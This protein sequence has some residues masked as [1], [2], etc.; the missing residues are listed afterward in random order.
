MFP[1]IISG[2]GA[3]TLLLP[4]GPLSGRLCWRAALSLLF[5]SASVNVAASRTPRIPRISR[6]SRSSRIHA[7]HAFDACHALH[8]ANEVLQNLSFLCG[9][10][11]YPWDRPRG[12]SSGSILTKHLRLSSNLG[13]R[14][15][16][17]PQQHLRHHWLRRQRSHPQSTRRQNR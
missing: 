4:A 3:A 10:G 12:M 5:W 2:Q 11:H 6:I 9:V 14:R 15:H 1:R 13:C 8:W 7:V 17:H 16:A